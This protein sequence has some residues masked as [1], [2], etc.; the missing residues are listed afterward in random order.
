MRIFNFKTDLVFSLICGWA[1]DGPERRCST[2]AAYS[3]FPSQM[4]KYNFLEPKGEK[5]R[6]RVSN[7]GLIAVYP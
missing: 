3:L 2:T 4:S 1:T 6:F 7:G 5:H